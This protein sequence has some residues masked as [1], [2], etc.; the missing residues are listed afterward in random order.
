MTL[1]GSGPPQ[2]EKLTKLGE[3]ITQPAPVPIRE[4]DHRRG[5][6]D[7]LVRLKVHEGRRFR[8]ADP[9]RGKEQRRRDPEHGGETREDRRAWLLDTPS[10]ELRDRGTR[11]PD[12]PSELSL[13]EIQSLACGTHRECEGWS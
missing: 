6:R 5:H 4:P 10:L 13:R 9:G 3:A 1:R 12:A 7:E 8:L 11:H 2:H